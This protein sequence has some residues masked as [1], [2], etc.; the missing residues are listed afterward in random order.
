MNAGEPVEE[1]PALTLDTLG[2]GCPI[3]VIELAKHI[4]EVPPGATVAVLSDDIAARTDI[5]VWCRMRG[6]DYVGESPVAGGVA[7]TVRRSR[8]S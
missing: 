8:P 4:G 7:Y 6:H 1:Q 3:P 5:P 2:R